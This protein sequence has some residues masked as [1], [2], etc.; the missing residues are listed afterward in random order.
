MAS[1]IQCYLTSTWRKSFVLHF[2]TNTPSHPWEGGHS[3]DSTLLMTSINRRAAAVSYRPSPTSSLS[4]QVHIWDGDQHRQEEGLG[5]HCRI[6]TESRDL[7]EQGTAGRNAVFQVS[8]HNSFKWE[9]CISGSQKQQW[10]WTES[11]RLGIAGV[12]SSIPKSGFKSLL[13]CPSCCTAAR[14]GSCSEKLERWI[15]AF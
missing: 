8:G 5:L 11:T 13:L 14:H 10:W 7:N 1:V 9:G 6:F 15:Q 3:I 2:R 12:S 4:V